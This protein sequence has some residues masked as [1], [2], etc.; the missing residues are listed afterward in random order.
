MSEGEL[1]QVRFF[2]SFKKIVSSSLSEHVLT[3]YPK[4]LD[5]R[6]HF[7]KMSSA[8]FAMPSGF[9]APLE[10]TITPTPLARFISSADV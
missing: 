8:W 10:N 1:P 6:S 3:S 2:A 7:D 4:F 9:A 5:L